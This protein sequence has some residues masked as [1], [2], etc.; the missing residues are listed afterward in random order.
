M[1]VTPLTPTPELKQK[2]ILSYYQVL[3]QENS[4]LIVLH[5]KTPEQEEKSLSVNQEVEEPGR[6]RGGSGP[7]CRSEVVS[8]VA[9]RRGG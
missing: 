7:V 8:A 9:S 4:K 1:T 6:I 3:E 2:D 5:A